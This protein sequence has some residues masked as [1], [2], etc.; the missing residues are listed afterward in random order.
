M[1]YKGHSP[2]APLCPG[3]GPIYRPE[4]ESRMQKT[5]VRHGGGRGRG[6]TW[7]VGVDEYT[8]LCIKRN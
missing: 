7:E 3:A 6:I 5:N 8:L 2:A 1:M 4:T